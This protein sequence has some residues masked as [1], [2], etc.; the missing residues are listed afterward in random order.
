MSS[1][2]SNDLPK[3]LP[4]QKNLP[5]YLKM[6]PLELRGGIYNILISEEDGNKEKLNLISDLSL[7]DKISYYLINE[8]ILRRWNIL[9]YYDLPGPTFSQTITLTNMQRLIESVEEEEKS[10][11]L[12]SNGPARGQLLFKLWAQGVR[13]IY[14]GGL[15]IF[16]SQEEVGSLYGKIQSK[17]DRTLLA[18]WP[19]INKALAGQDQK[20]NFES[21]DE[22]QVYIN[23]LTQEGRFPSITEFSNKG[24]KIIPSFGMDE[25]LPNLEKLIINYV[26]IKFFPELNLNYLRTL[27]L[28]ACNLTTK[29]LIN[30]FYFKNLKHL[31]L[32][33]NDIYRIPSLIKELTSLEKLWICNNFLKKIGP[34]STLT[35]LKLINFNSNR[36]KNIDSISSLINLKSISFNNNEIENLPEFLFTL[37]NLESA[38]FM[39]NK[40]SIIPK[41]ISQNKELKIDLESNFITRIPETFIKECLLNEVAINRPMLL[42]GHNPL[43]FISADIVKINFCY[44]LFG[45]KYKEFKKYKCSSKFSELCKLM[46]LSDNIKEIKKAYHKLKES[47]RQ[48]I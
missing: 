44:N 27:K 33:D 30:L 35:K 23:V 17:K 10:L 9:K 45:E 12:D 25:Y 14:E 19:I 48:L 1:L 46:I 21:V 39:K 22:I 8:W 28:V 2:V 16:P 43:L 36:I 40:I 29:T 13:K 37:P 26:N 24:V 6:L 32:S 34:I 11:R 4:K 41:S 5:N 31:D 47:D 3:D 38:Y 18:F 42:I 15:K 7:I 20:D